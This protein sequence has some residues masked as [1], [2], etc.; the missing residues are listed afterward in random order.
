[1]SDIDY[2][3]VFGTEEPVT[4]AGEEGTEAAEPSETGAADHAAQ[5]EKAQEAA[6]P[7]GDDSTPD[8]EEGTGRTGEDSGFSAARRRAEA[9]RNA[10][11]AKARADAQAE[12][13]R[14]VDQFFRNS[15]LVNPYTK[16]PITT[17]AEYETYRKQ[18]QARQKQTVLEKTGMTPEE[19]KT[20]V[21]GLPEVQAARQA[22]EAA[23]K[24]A[25]AARER[26]ARAL[27]EEQL[28]EVQGLDPSI[29]SLQD[30]SKMETYPQ[31]YEMVKRGYSIVDAYKLANYDALTA[32]AA[33]AS[34]QAAVNAVQS[35]RHLSAT[36]P[37]GEGAV[38]VPDSVLEEYRVLN[39][40]AS[41]EEIQKHYQ[42][43]IRHNREA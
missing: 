28:K 34:R 10:A 2:G 41:R 20:F 5:G 8:S 19:Y 9:E 37:R 18:F 15:G 3:A 24:A 16:T 6:A 39:P 38:S 13:Q 26:E 22:K 43:Y 4:T 33:A 40:G 32:R 17:K 35:K 7:A 11:I 14:V 27:V 42:N 36:K 12:A 31:L 25:R 1:M 23:D 21:D 30:L 29:K